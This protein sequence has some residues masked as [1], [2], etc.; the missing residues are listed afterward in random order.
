MGRQLVL[1]AV[2]LVVISVLIVPLAHALAPLL[3]AGGV[4]IL[5]LAGLWMIASAPFRRGL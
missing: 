4:L 1:A 3:K 5:A 2:A